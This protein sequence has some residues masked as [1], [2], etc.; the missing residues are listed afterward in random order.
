[1][2]HGIVIDMN[3][4]ITG[5]ALYLTGL[6]LTINILINMFFGRENLANIGI[7]V[8]IER[9]HRLSPFEFFLDN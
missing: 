9:E 8:I 5:W 6:L 2:Y 4:P 7:F 3:L 1:M